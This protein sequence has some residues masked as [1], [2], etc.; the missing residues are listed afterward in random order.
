[1]KLELEPTTAAQVLCQVRSYGIY[2]RQAAFGHAASEYF[3]IPCQFS[4]RR[5]LHIN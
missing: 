2:T 4:F 5:L 1:M 3:G